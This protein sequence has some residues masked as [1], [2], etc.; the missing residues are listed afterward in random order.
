TAHHLAPSWHAHHLPPSVKLDRPSLHVASSV[1]GRYYD[2]TNGQFITVDP[3]ITETGQPYSYAG[4]DP[5]DRADPPGLSWLYIL[6]DKSTG[7][8]YYVGQSMVD[9]DARIAAHAASGQFNP[10]EDSVSG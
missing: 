8:P 6:I 10:N 4:D 9:V 1:V 2:P 7:L 5:I 3:A